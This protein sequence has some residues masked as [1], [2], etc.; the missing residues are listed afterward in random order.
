MIKIYYSSIY[1]KSIAEG[2]G[3]VLSRWDRTVDIQIINTITKA[4][5]KARSNQPQWIILGLQNVGDYIPDKYIVW[6]FEQFEVEGPEF[7]SQFWARMSQ[8]EQIWDYSLEN[9]QW[10]GLHKGLGASH[11]PLGWMPQMKIP[12]PINQW[13]QRT[14]CFAFVGLMNQRR[15]DIIK[16][17]YQLAKDTN[18]NMYLSNKCWDTEYNTIYSMT[19]YGLNIHYYPGKT[20]LEVHRIIPLILNGI[21]VISE[22]SGDPWYNQLFDQ[23]VTWAEPES[24][25]EIISKLELMDL[26][27]AIAELELRKRLLIQS[28]DM[29]KFFIQG[30]FDKK[31]TC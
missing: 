11:L 22:K 8:A 3:W 13:D 15:R 2:L 10:L 19:K 30:G 27:T 21:W 26:P 17:C 6:N 16:P 31:L 29:Y 23:L 25:A 28:C 18:L 20:I 7:N 12:T 14:N 5:T 24:F 1:F 4:D 9:I